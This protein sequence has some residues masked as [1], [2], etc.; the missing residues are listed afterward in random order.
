MQIKEKSDALIVNEC[1]FCVIRFVCV[2][3]EKDR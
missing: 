3:H 2:M 1:A